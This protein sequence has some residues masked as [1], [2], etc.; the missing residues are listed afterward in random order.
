MLSQPWVKSVAAIVI[1]FGALAG[2]IFWH[3]AHSEVSI[4]TTVLDAPMANIAPTSGGV[5]NALY[6]KEGDRVP[7]NAPIAQV[8]TETLFAKEG[9]VVSG[10]PQVIGS[11]FAPGQTV[12]SVVDTQKMR[13]VATIDETKGLSK[14]KPGQRVTF[15]VDAFPGKTYA[16]TVDE[17]SPVSNDAGVAFSISDKRPVKKF[18]VYARFDTSAYPELKSGMSAK[19]TVHL[20]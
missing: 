18:N 16:G 8:G 12:V 20:K 2:F 11:Y 15:T 3:T 1:I 13:A 14:I 10:D 19:M 17:I 7:A 9:G 4:D 5:L 6:V